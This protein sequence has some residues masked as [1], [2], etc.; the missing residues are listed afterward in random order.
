MRKGSLLASLLLFSLLLPVRGQQPQPQPSPPSGPQR[1]PAAQPQQQNAPRADDT[2]VVRITTNLVQVDAVVT[3]DDKQVTNLK[4]EDFEILEDGHAQTITNFA[5][6]LNVPAASISPA[7][8]AA[9]GKNKDAPPV[10]PATTQPH[11]V[12]RTIA[13]VVDDLGVSFESVGQIRR[14]LHK[15]IDEQLQP[16]D[17]VAI[18]RTGGEVGALQQ[19]TTDRRLLHSAIERVRWNP[20]SRVGP[21]VFTPQGQDEWTSPCGSSSPGATMTGTFVALRFILKGMRG[22]PGRKSLVI[23]SD[24]L[25]VED[26]NSGPGIQ[27]TPGNGQVREAG[28]RGGFT[29]SIGYGEP[30]QRIAE[31]AIRA[32]VVIYAVDTRGLQTTGLTAADRISFPPLGTRTTPD[33]MNRLIVGKRARDLMLGREGSDFIAKQTG[34]FLIRNSNDF[35]LQRVM[36]DQQGYYLLGYRPSGETF[37]RRFHHITVRVKRHGL[38][39]RTRAGF[40]GVSDSDAHPPEPTVRDQINLALASPFG[41]VDIAVRLTPLFANAPAKG[42]LIRSLL[43]FDAR[44]LT[45]T[46]EPDGWHKT[47]FDLSTIIFGDNGGIVS[48]TSQ[49]ETLRLHGQSYDRVLRDGL[50]YSFD[51]PARNSGVYQFRVAVRDATS[52]RLGTA[53]QFVEVPDL[54]NGQLA[55]SGIAVSGS[56]D[57][58][59]SNTKPPATSPSASSDQQ[60]AAVETSAGPAVRRF[61]KSPNLF[62]GYTIYNAQLDKTTHLPRLTAQTRV[63]RDGKAIFMGEPIPIDLAD[64]SD[65]ERLNA[66]GLLRLGAGLP[67]GEYILQIIVTD[68]LAK[69][70]HRTATQ[71][72]DFEIVK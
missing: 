37:D 9:A 6:I 43:Y 23:F 49:T 25:P 48:Q 44:E 14:Q 35:E 51:T 16:N 41:A 67:P 4:A 7:N 53:G 54:R 63:F 66:G 55:L 38:T 60:K 69:E 20:C 45:F 13:L 2:D 12:R 32:S 17:L 47:V 31:L 33:E 1:P 57:S 64:Q 21:F 3:K 34:G 58:Q 18:I 62:F 30:L 68:H 36:E 59:D 52:S 15:F 8:I 50:V 40:Y 39:V 29:Y 72:I 22:L 28:N 61:Q 42:S 5:Y 11:D 27:V 65:L 19:F 46:D 24:S 26:L 70:K 71:W 10:L 56:I